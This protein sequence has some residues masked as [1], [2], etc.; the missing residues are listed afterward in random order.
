MT[1]KKEDIACP[2]IVSMYNKIMGGVDLADMLIALYRLQCKA[3]R[4]YIKFFRHMVDIA[5]VIPWIL[6]KREEILRGVP[7]KSLKYLKMFSFE[8]ANALIYV[9]MPAS[10]DRP[11]K[12]KS[13]EAVKPPLRS[14]L[15]PNP[16]DDVQ[17]DNIGHWPVPVSDK[18][19]GCLCQSYA[20][21]TCQKCK[22]TLCLLQDRNC[23]IAFHT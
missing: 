16:V 14:K 2:K 21:M 13:T 18:K 7:E 15:I 19:R 6:Y 17:Y 10:R 4:W 23:F 3:T 5:K 20:R 8:I 1:E 22:V 12:R 11:S 9:M